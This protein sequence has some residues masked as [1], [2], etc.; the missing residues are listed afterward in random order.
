[1]MNEIDYY[2]NLFTL[3][4]IIL[5]LIDEVDNEKLSEWLMYIVR[6]PEAQA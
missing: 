6:Y 3:E 5:S 2:V 4:S 1:M